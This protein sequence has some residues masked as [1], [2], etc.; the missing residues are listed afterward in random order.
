[1]KLDTLHKILNIANKYKE[2]WASLSQNLD[3]IDILNNDD[4]K[5]RLA[6]YL[7][8]LERS[9]E[10]DEKTVKFIKALRKSIVNNTTYIDTVKEIS[11]A[12]KNAKEAFDKI[13]TELFPKL[14]RL[15][16]ASEQLTE[17]NKLKDRVDFLKYIQNELF[18]EVNYIQERRRSAS[19]ATRKRSATGCFIFIRKYNWTARNSCKWKLV[20]LQYCNHEL[21]IYRI[22][23]NLGRS[24]I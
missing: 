6:I 24:E 17:F 12:F 9:P 21:W 7:K 3:V 18:E 8:N 20:F 4:N 15:Q 1:L 19:Q 11:L 5:Q 13:E 23:K 10:N 2:I 16:Q 14:Q 22:P